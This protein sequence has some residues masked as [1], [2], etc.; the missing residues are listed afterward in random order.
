MPQIIVGSKIT[1]DASLASIASATYGIS[2]LYEPHLHN[3]LDAV[4]EV[5]TPTITSPLGDKQIIVYAKAS[6]DNVIWQS[7][8]ESGVDD[9]SAEQLTR[10]GSL[11]VPIT[12]IHTA[13]FSI[14]QAFGWLPPYLKFI[15]KNACGITIGA[16]ISVSV[17]EITGI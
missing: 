16:G 3:P 11:L 15:F 6:L 5:T 1:I 14:G 17:S 2:S 7:G 9:T 8:P 12:G 4:L 10:L 13:Q